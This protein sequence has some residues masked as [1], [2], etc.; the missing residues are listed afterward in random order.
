MQVVPNSESGDWFEQNDYLFAPNGALQYWE[1]YY[2][3]FNPDEPSKAWYAFAWSQ[4]GAVVDQASKFVD[5]D[6][7]SW[8]GTKPQRPPLPPLQL[9]TLVDQYKLNGLL[10]EA[11]VELVP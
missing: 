11:K 7:H 3:S 6:G 4:G 8:K 5:S 10:R 2:G 1:K 9:K